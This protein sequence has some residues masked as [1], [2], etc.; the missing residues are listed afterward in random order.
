K[1]E[2]S[3]IMGVF[4][5]DEDLSDP[6][7]VEKYWFDNHPWI[8]LQVLTNTMYLASNIP[9]VAHIEEQEQQEQQQEQQELQE[10]V[11]TDE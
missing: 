2:V 5:T 3:S 7:V 1:E 6:A 10:Q 8:K 9:R 4:H 11:T